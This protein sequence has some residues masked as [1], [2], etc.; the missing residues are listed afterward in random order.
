VWYYEAYE[1]CVNP[2]IVKIVEV[3]EFYGNEEELPNEH[4]GNLIEVS[5]QFFKIE[6]ETPDLCI[7][8]MHTYFIYSFI[9]QTLVKAYG[10]H[11]KTRS[12]HFTSTDPTMS[13]ETCR[14][15]FVPRKQK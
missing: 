7:E 13:Q 5:I 14:R 6:D 11:H 9:Q 10:V 8:E 3:K 15:D 2:G 12:H 4:F 1:F